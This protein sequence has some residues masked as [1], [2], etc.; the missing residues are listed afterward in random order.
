M[1]AHLADWHPWEQYQDFFMAKK[2]LGG[3]A[4]L[5]ESHWIDLM[6][7]FFGLPQSI[8]GKVEKISD[9]DIETDDNVDF[10][11]LYPD[12]QTSV[13]AFGPLWTAT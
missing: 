6:V 2:N 9:L 12:R 10:L 1:S 13:W 11:S 8:I 4:L 5:D 7:W 3:G